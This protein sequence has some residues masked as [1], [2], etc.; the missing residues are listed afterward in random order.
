MGV[1]L[2]RASSGLSTHRHKGRVDRGSRLWAPGQSNPAPSSLEEWSG[3]I[4][5]EKDV[6]TCSETEAAH[7]QERICTNRQKDKMLS[8]DSGPVLRRRCLVFPLQFILV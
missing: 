3:G 6:K 2:A 7:C 8:F 1:G 4:S 5:K